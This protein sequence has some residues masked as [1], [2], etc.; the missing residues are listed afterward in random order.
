MMIINVIIIFL[1]GK[2]WIF[3]WYTVSYTFIARYSLIIATRQ[4]AFL[5][6]FHDRI[7]LFF[8]I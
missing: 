2:I 7:V 8:S 5:E 1:H 6:G 4:E 3:R